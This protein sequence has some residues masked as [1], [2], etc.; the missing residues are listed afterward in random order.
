MPKYEGDLRDWL[1]QWPNI[2]RQLDEFIIK[3]KRRQVSGSYTVAKRTTELIRNCLGTCRYTT[4]GQLIER[5]RDIGKMLVAAQPR[6]LAIGNIIRRVLYVIREE[7]IKLAAASSSP[8]MDGRYGAESQAS[9]PQAPSLQTILGPAPI[10]NSF[11]ANLKGFRQSLLEGVNELVEEIEDLHGPIAEQSLEHIHAN[12]IILTFGKSTS[13]EGFLKA[14]RKKREFKVI[15]AES[16]PLFEGQEMARLL[17]LAGIDTTVIN[18]SAI[19]AMMAR[20]N[21]VVMPT[22]AVMANGGLMTRAGGH[23]VALAAKHHSVPLVCV[24]GLFKLC[25]LYPHDQNSFNDLKSP[26]PVLHFEEKAMDQV[27]VINPAY[28]YVPPELVDLFITNNGGH[29]PSYIYRLLQEY[30]SPEDNYL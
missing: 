15:V 30:Y 8:T 19:F 16:A 25:P 21:K 13:V 1:K 9:V 29:Q 2:L 23:M 6:E 18:D 24:T 12:E 4:A 17:S 28:D 26:N 27:D 10:D 22:R 5:I 3:L 14:A 20:V 11:S 7:Y